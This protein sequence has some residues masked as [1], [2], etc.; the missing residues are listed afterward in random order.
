VLV[1]DT[2]VGG[3]SVRVVADTDDE[4]SDTFVPLTDRIVRGVYVVLAVS[5][6]TVVVV[7]VT[8]V[9]TAVPL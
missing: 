7:P 4:S 2:L 5:P 9:R 1:T 3:L 8:P 6:E